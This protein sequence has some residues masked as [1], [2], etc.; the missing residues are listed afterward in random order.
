[1]VNFIAAEFAW[2]A[3]QVQGMD[4]VRGTQPFLLSEKQ[5]PR[6]GRPG[7]PLTHGK[8]GTYPPPLVFR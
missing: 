5:F 3:S 2:Q 7:K 4:E 1:M 8:T 6:A